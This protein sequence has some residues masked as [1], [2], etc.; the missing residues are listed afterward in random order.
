MVNPLLCQINYIGFNFAPRGWALCDGQLLPI[1]S[2]TAMFSLMGTAFGGDGRT[3][4]ALP[5][6]RGRT[7]VGV[8]TGAGL[9]PI[10]W[11]ER[12]GQETIVISTAHMPSHNHSLWGTNNDAL[13][14]KPTNALLGKTG[15]SA[16]P[17]YTVGKNADLQMQTTSIGNT[18][19]GQAINIRN[20]FLGLYVCIAM[21]GV[22][23]S[24]S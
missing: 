22:Y 13:S 5:D 4:F 24:R 6:L 11:A 20:P 16:G 3:T 9:T 18:G 8:G 21:Q 17:I 15:G 23:P 19:G 12:G 1:A 2:N 14:G 10:S 7:P